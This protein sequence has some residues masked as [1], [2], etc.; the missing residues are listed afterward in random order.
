MQVH[1]EVREWERLWTVI[2]NSFSISRHVEFFRWLQDE[3]HAYV[4]HDVLVAVWGDFASGR[5]NY[6]VASNIPEIRT[7]KIM[8][9]CEVDPLMGDLY[10]RWRDGGEKWFILNHFNLL[11]MNRSKSNSCVDALEQ[12]QSILVHGI[13]DRR[14]NIDSLYVFFDTDHK[15][16][17][18]GPILELLV[19]QI[20]AAL[21]RVECLA[22]LIQ[23]DDNVSRRLVC[24]ISDREHEI[25][26]WVRFGK[27]NHE[28]GMILGISHNTVKNH[29]KRIFQKMGVTSRAQAVAKYSVVAQG[30]AGA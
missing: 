20:D 16:D 4:P 10:H 14:E 8:N 9:G 3:V 2:R 28:I 21:R 1:R 19:P 24:E 29:L 15:I 26:S 18:Q 23:E 22:P 25:M 30:Q 5:L 27:T 13:R 7:Q 11:G 17:A 6:D 12:M